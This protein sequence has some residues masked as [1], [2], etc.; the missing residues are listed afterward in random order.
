MAG[1]PLTPLRLIGFDVRR[2]PGSVADLLMPAERRAASLLQPDGPEVLSAD[3]SIWPSLFCTKDAGTAWPAS[4]PDVVTVE[5]GPGADYFEAF[6]LWPDLASMRSAYRPSPQGDCGIAV[7]LLLPEHYGRQIAGDAWFEA[8]IAPGATPDTPASDWPFLGFDV[9]NSGLQS[10]LAGFGPCDVA[11]ELRA[12]WTGVPNRFHLFDRLPDALE[13]CS[14][15][16]GP[17]AEDGP[18]FV[19]ALFLFW[20]TLGEIAPH[21]SSL[22]AEGP[23]Q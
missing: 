4:L 1:H 18:F 6:D 14:S 10:A 17:L 11:G 16:S 7:A 22:Q 2:S 23:A 19:A 13:F 9:V 12:A 3:R 21:A 15:I 5:D 8:V 20:D